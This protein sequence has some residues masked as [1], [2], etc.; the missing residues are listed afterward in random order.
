MKGTIKLANKLEING[1]TVAELAYDTDTIDAEAFIAAESM[2]TVKATRSA[3]RNALTGVTMEMDYSFALFLGYF[4][5]I[6]VKPEIDVTDLERLHG[7][8]LLAVQKV[9]RNFLTASEG[10][11]EETSDEP[12][13]I[14]PESITQ[15]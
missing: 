10:S 11:P 9:G 15:A 3:S 7:A 13:G 4:A 14:T 8:D 5:I 2:K 6:G 1:K 12:S